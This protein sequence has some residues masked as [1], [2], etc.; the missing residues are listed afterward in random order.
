MKMNIKF[1][2]ILLAACTLANAQVAP[3]ATGPGQATVR[4]SARYSQTAVHYSTAG[5]EI[6]SITSANVDYVHPNL[7]HPFTLNYGG[8]YRRSIEGQDLGTGI[9]HRLSLSQGLDLR[10]W[11]ATVT[12]DVSYT[13]ESPTVGFSGIPGTGEPISG[14]GTNP[15]SGQSIL[16]LNTRSLNNIADVNLGFALNYA[17][18]LNVI[19][20]S[21]LQRYPVGNFPDTDHQNVSAGISRRIDA[22]NS[23]SG[24][25]AYSRF[26]FGASPYSGGVSGSFDTNSVSVDYLRRWSRQLKT[27]VVVG[28]QWTG[29]SDSVLVPRAKGIMANASVTYQFRSEFAEMV[30][31][32]GIS[33]AS[34]DFPGATI[35]SVN[36][37]ISRNFGRRLTVEVMST[38]LHTAALQKVIGTS[39]GRVGS[40]QVS[41]RLG[42]YLSVFA[43]Y[44]AVDQSSSLSG[45]AQQANVL[46]QLYQV[47]SFGIAYSPREARLRQ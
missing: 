10:K 14:P 40:A 34:I 23:I 29:N 47:V 6:I 7:R 43:S 42:P 25:Y 32:R 8:G 9:F 26:S 24:Q 35:D 19:G 37:A 44:T 15:T 13:P 46:N 11:N 27:D 18:T 30:Y 1:T 16:T 3:E 28:P 12:D 33:G 5:D 2:I 21:Q 36:G 20:T 17:T 41:Q 4:Y 38:Y 31:S 39:I 22:R 45:L